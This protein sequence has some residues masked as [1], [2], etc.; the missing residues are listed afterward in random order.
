MEQVNP[1]SL[2]G[3]LFNSPK[4]SI[5]LSYA[6]II[7]STAMSTIQKWQPKWGMENWAEE[8][9]GNPH[10]SCD[11]PVHINVWHKTTNQDKSRLTF[12]L[13]SSLIIPFFFH[14]WRFTFFPQQDLSLL[15][16]LAKRNFYSFSLVRRQCLLLALYWMVLPVR[17]RIH[18]GRGQFCLAF[19]ARILLI[20]KVFWD[21]Y[22]S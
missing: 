3:D 9:C 8:K 17:S 5:I 12:P 10:F 19:L 22:V 11:K 7:G 15:H 18:W 16:L 20:L 13:L 2:K 6:H 14:A 1:F 21:G 4:R